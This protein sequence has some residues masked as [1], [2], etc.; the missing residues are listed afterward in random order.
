MGFDISEF[1]PEGNKNFTVNDLP[2]SEKPRERIRY[3]GASGVS[4]QEL[5]AAILGRGIKGESV[6]VTAQRII[7]KFNGNLNKMSEATIEDLMQIRG[8]GVAKAAQLVACFELMNRKAQ[9]EK[10]LYEFLNS[11]TITS[12]DIVCEVLN[13]QV[14]D[15]TKE[16]FYVISL[17]IRNKIIAL[18]EISVGSLSASIAHPREIFISAIKNHAAQI[19]IAHNHP[20]CDPNP[21][22]EDNKITRRLFDAGKILGINLID[23][24]IFCKN[25]ANYSYKNNNVIF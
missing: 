11:K 7:K 13:T 5:L 14:I 21:S 25:G 8:I 9:E 17:N 19:I 15:H 4:L 18:E 20:S 24:I 23:H 10:G 3:R 12:P 16:H 1:E 6:M 2:D 22:E